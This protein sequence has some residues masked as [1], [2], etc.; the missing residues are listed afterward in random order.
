MGDHLWTRRGTRERAMSSNSDR[1][2]GAFLKEHDSSK[3]PSADGEGE[4]DFD[5]ELADLERDEGLRQHGAAAGQ[6]EGLP[7]PNT[8]SQPVAKMHPAPVICIWIVLS[9]TVILMNAYILKDLGFDFPVTLTTLHLAYASL[10]T[11]LLRRFTHLLYGLDR[12]DMSWDRYLRNIVP[13]GALFSA[14]LV[15]SNLAYI[16]LEV[17]FIQMLKAF[18]AVVAYFMSVFMGLE[19]YSRRTASIVLVISS[20]VAIASYGEI[21]FV[22]S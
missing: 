5:H 12:I 11:R 8:Q 6:S 1:K 7:V 18:V 3:R 22:L 9:S 16:T 13:I 21:N 19:Q 4:G 20:G 10:G 17:S 2:A 14:S 15:F